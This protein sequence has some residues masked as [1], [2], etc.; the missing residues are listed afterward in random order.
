MINDGNF[1]VSSRSQTVLSGKPTSNVILSPFSVKLLMSLLAEAAGSNTVTERELASVLP[2]VNSLFQ[3]REL[4]KGVLRSLQV[5][6]GRWEIPR[7]NENWI[8]QIR[9]CL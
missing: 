7:Q 3:A 4:Y 1:V 2:G 6:W 9:I 5:G 8:I